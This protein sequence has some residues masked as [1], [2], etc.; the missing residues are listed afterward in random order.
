ML[1]TRIC[2]KNL[3]DPYLSQILMIKLDIFHL[4]Q[5][6]SVFEIGYPATFPICLCQCMVRLG[7]SWEFAGLDFLFEKRNIQKCLN[8]NATFPWTPTI[9]QTPPYPPG[10]RAPTS[11]Y[12]QGPPQ[13]LLRHWWSTSGKFNLSW[14]FPLNGCT[15]KITLVNRWSAGDFCRPTCIWQW[16]CPRLTPTVPDSPWLS[17]TVPDYPRLSLTTP[18]CPR[19]SWA[20]VVELR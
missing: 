7:S 5:T 17:S 11:V 9:T 20:T 10:R 3:L 2:H 12:A 16:T 13:S 1:G 14:A 15:H 18:T 19:L 8:Q 6:V 4:H